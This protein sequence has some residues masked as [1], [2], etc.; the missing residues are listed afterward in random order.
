MEEA[1]LAADHL[2]QF[3]AFIHLHH[4]VGAADEF[5]LHVELGDGG[6]VAVFLDASADFWIFEHVYRGDAFGIYAHGFE[7]LHGAAGEA[8]LG[9]AGVAFHEKHDVVAFD[10]AVNTLLG[11][12][13]G[14]S[15]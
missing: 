3:P 15:F 8:A 7:D 10:D 11:V 2:L 12:A 13:H 14:D 9:E 4:D 5:A 1:A 6:P